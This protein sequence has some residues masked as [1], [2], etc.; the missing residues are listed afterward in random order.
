VQAWS[1]PVVI[2]TYQPMPADIYPMFLEKRVY[3]GSSGRVYPNP[4]TDRISEE[5]ADRAWEAVH[6]ENEYLRLVILPEIGG[7]IHVGLDKT[8]GYDFF[9]RQNV[10][11]PALVGLLGP[12]ISGGVEFNWPQHHRPSTFMPVSWK[13][14]EEADGSRTVWLSEHDPMARMKGMVGIRLRPGRAY[15]EARVRLYNRTPFVQTFLW[16]ANVAVAVHDQYQSFFPPDVTYV[17][18]HAKRAMST[19]PMARGTYYGVDYSRGPGGGTDL[20]WYRNIPVPTSYMAMGS[21]QDFFGGYDYRRQAGLVHI[22]DHH[23]APGKKQWTWGNHEFGYAW[24]R[25]LTETDGPYVELMAGVYTDNQP[26]FSFLHP[27][28]TK[29]FSQFWYPIQRIGP[30]QNANLEAAVSLSVERKV[31]RVGVAVTAP[32]EG[33]RVRL[34][35]RQATVLEQTLDLRPGEPLT[36]EVELPPRT[37]ETD[38]RLSVTDRGGREVIAYAPARRPERATPPPATEPPVPQA[39]GT[40]E[41]LYLT[42]V[43]LEQYRHA[44]RD[45]EPYWREALRREATD[46]RS[47]NALGLWHLR[48]GEFREAEAHFRRAIE[49]QTRRNAN[50][51]D[52]E[53]SYNLGLAL[54]LLRRTDEAY[55]AFFKATWNYAWQAPGFYALAEI[56]AQRG[57]WDAALDHLERS[58]LTNVANLKA[59]DLQAVVLRRTGRSEAALKVS[60]DTLALDRLDVWA[61]NERILALRALGRDDDARQALEDLETW[62]R[63]DEQTHMDLA[64]DY[65]AAGLRH[66]AIEVLGRRLPDQEHLFAGPLIHYALA[67]LLDQEGRLEAAERQRTQ[68]ATAPTDYAFPFRLE[69]L[70]ILQAA[71]AAN[72]RDPRAPYYLGNLLYDKR[73]HDDAIKAWEAARRLDPTFPIVLRNLAIAAYNVRRQP[74]RART[75]FGMAFAADPK[76]PRLLYEFDQLLKKLNEPPAR[77]LAR[78]ERNRSLVAQRDDL[79][80]ELA[81]LYNELGRSDDALALIANHRF[82]P[83]EG[84]EGLVS[85]QYEMAH[86]RLGQAE[87]AADR[88]AEARQHFTAAM[89]YP[90]NL[91][92]GR[93][94]LTPETHLEY[95]QALACQAVGATPEARAWLEQASRPVAPLLSESTFYRALAIR[96]LGRDAEAEALFR[97]L[98]NAARRQARV[99]VSIDYFATSLPSFL[100]FEDDLQLRNRVTACYLEGLA[101]LGLGQRRRAERAFRQVLELDVNHLGAAIQLAA[102][103][104]TV[105]PTVSAEVA[106]AV[107]A[108]QPRRG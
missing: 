63:G 48:R 72:P 44:T 30:P 66:E 64:L 40:V 23:I 77:R 29:A 42:G 34:T 73:R 45:P 52:G 8:N 38:L 25:N 75:L 2:P 89:Q 11:K 16:W 105:E 70:E 81:T 92:E 32:L 59:R 31:A 108:G 57:D 53:P 62:T 82:Q 101:R 95:H 102:L 41:E 4:F 36:A 86:L 97:G 76:D 3:Q 22:A 54:R 33:A 80:V 20:S 51:G 39:I 78:L 107:L 85:E 49:T 35:S 26:D 47:N 79:M 99:G 46:L 1:E 87:L 103:V 17:A 12:W 43:H 13:I 27:Y 7:R 98:L 50:P 69:E 55:D 93:H 21:D 5:R 71:R 56:D 61:A 88:P 19:F 74:S 96:G 28:E 83:W 84:G 15:L 60:E 58:L 100:L 6:L 106:G 67:W 90:E 65:V 9:Y 10:I 94:L 14:E 24:D 37:R 68:A 91:G 18:D 104:E